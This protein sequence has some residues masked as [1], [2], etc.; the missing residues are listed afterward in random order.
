M[1][2]QPMVKE[3]LTQIQALQAQVNN[4]VA[5]AAPNATTTAISADTP[6]T[7]EVEDII[8]YKTKHGSAV[9]EQG[10][11][12]L[13]NKA[14]S[15]GFSMSLSQSVVFVEVLHCKATQTGWNQGSKQITIFN[16][17]TGKSVD[18]IKEYG[19]ID[20]AMLKIQCEQFCKAGGAD[21]Q[22]R[23]KQNNTMMCTCLAKSLTASAHAKLL[24]HRSEYTFDGVEYA[25]LMYKIIMRLTTMDSV[26]TT[27]SLRENLQT[28]ATYA[29]TVKGNIDKI[30]EEFDKNYSQIIAR[31]ATVDDPIQTLFDAYEAVPCYNFKKYIEQQQ[32]D[33]L[34]GKLAGL[35]HEA[36]RKM[37]KSK[38]DWLVN[39]KK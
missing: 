12:P 24:T 21:A 35:T 2:N 23:A 17:A 36:L 3:L 9:Y 34:D 27:Q 26:A 6:N 22:S 20:E 37:A 4:L 29:A 14:V 32:N 5:A 39:N 18:V 11:Q 13:D 33:Y 10:C 28:L 7:L 30:H 15:K 8:N 31:G 25:P 1:A 16:N 19:Q 38:F